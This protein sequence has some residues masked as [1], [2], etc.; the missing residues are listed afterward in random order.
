MV[1]LLSLIV[2][3]LILPDV[4]LPDTAFQRNSSPLA[5][6]A[7]SHQVLQ[8]SASAGVFRPSFQLGLAS[9][10]HLQRRETRAGRREDLAIHLEILRC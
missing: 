6:R 1:L 9:S 10:R 4:D 8:A 3:V 7:L 5:I 2:I